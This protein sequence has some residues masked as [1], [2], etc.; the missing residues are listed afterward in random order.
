[1][2]PELLNKCIKL[3]ALHVRLNTQK[4]AMQKFALRK[5][6]ICQYCILDCYMKL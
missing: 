2:L 4:F 5:L 1:M 3:T 6:L